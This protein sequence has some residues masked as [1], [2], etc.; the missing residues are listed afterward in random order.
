V[1]SPDGTE[2][3]YIPR[4]RELYRVALQLEPGPT[5]GIPEFIS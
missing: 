2:I 1:F 5:L 4:E 3:H